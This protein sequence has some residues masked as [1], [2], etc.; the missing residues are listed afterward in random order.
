MILFTRYLMGGLHSFPNNTLQDWIQQKMSSKVIMR[1]K[2]LSALT[3]SLSIFTVLYETSFLNFMHCFT[4]VRASTSNYSQTWPLKLPNRLST[5]KQTQKKFHIASNINLE[6]FSPIHYPNITTIS[7][8][9]Q[10][11]FKKVDRQKAPHFRLT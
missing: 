7:T 2:R 6:L 5:A 1:Y 8:R 3:S 10:K 11:N 4:K 9:W